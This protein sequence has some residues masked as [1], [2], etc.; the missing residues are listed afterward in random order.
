M[1]DDRT[2]T[3]PPRSR[4]WWLMF[5]AALLLDAFGFT[6]GLGYMTVPSWMSWMPPGAGRPLPR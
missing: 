6:G 1:D 3:K 5:P 2:T 4:W